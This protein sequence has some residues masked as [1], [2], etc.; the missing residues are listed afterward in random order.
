MRTWQSYVQSFSHEATTDSNVLYKSTLVHINVRRASNP[1][2]QTHR[3]RTRNELCYAEPIV[4][5]KP[6]QYSDHSTVTLASPN[7]SP[8][9]PA[10][11]IYAHCRTRSQPPRTS[12]VSHSHRT[13]SNSA[14]FNFTPKTEAI[15]LGLTYTSS[16][17]KSEERFSLT[18]T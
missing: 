11:P 8:R 7:P 13:T 14:R 18:L 5:R 9:P 15:L 4:F 12:S 17:F 3:T 2:P 6:A 16:M 1:S 10:L